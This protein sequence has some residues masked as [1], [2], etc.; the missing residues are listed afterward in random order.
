MLPIHTITYIYSEAQGQ[1]NFVFHY[2]YNG[3][4]KIT[5]MLYS[6]IILSFT[7]LSSYRTPSAI[8]HLNTSQVFNQILSYGNSKS[9]FPV[10]F[11]DTSIK[12]LE[13]H[14]IFII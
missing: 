7:I 11:T 5:P 10:H 14:S 8:N 2:I 12:M 9:C 1:Q 13:H 6:T 3:R 4:K